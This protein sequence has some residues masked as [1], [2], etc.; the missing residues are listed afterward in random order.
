MV[1]TH[2][3]QLRMGM[4][5]YRLR[6]GRGRRGSGRSRNGDSQQRERQR[7]EREREQGEREQLERAEKEQTRKG[8]SPT[9][10]VAHSNLFASTPLRARARILLTPLPIRMPVGPMVPTFHKRVTSSEQLASAPL[11]A[12]TGRLLRGL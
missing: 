9:S 1:E 8:V 4:R 7:R 11:G 12:W 5:R 6:Q 2:P 10:V 3:L